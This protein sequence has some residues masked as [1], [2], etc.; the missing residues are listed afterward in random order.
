MQDGLA[1]GAC[2]ARGVLAIERHH[3]RTG[4]GHAVALLQGDAALLPHS[5]KR[6]RHRRA[7]DAADDET[8]EVGSGEGGMLRHELIDRGHAEKHVDAIRRVADQLQREAGIERAHDQHGAAGMQ[9]R[10]GVAVESA[11]VEQ[12]Q[13]GQEHRRRRDVGRTAEIDAVP[14]RHAMGDDRAL[15]LPGSARGVHDG[16]DIIERHHLR[17]VE[18]ICAC[19]RRLVGTTRPKQQRRRDAAQFCHR[20]RD[21][22]ELGVVDHERRRRIA[23]DVLKLGDG[24]AGVQGQENR[25]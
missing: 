6:H 5:Q 2:L 20:K 11:G 22:G 12:R 16:R 13:H 17:L 7:A 21:I 23:D 25:P 24:E 14:E 10:I 15:R 3:R 4:L 19:D 1:G 9:H 8:A 18:R